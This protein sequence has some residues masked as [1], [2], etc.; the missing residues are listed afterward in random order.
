[1]NAYPQASASTT[2]PILY[3]NPHPQI[4]G[5]GEIGTVSS[6]LYGGV[7][8]TQN[9]ALLSRNIKTA[10]VVTNI[11]IWPNYNP[12]TYINTVGLYYSFDNN[13]TIGYSIDYFHVGEVWFASKYDTTTSIRG[14]P[15]QYYH[16]LRYAHTFFE[17]LSAGIGIKIIHSDLAP[18]IKSSFYTF[19][20][21]LGIDYRKKFQMT[22]KSDFRLD[23]GLSAQDIGPKIIYSKNQKQME[24][25]IPID[26]AAGTM[27]T[28]NYLINEKLFSF[29]MAYQVET[30]VVP[31][32]NIY[33][34]SSQGWL[35][36]IEK[37]NSSLL[38]PVYGYFGSF[39]STNDNNVMKP[40]SFIN[41]FGTEFRL[42][43]KENFIF[44]LRGGHIQEFE[45]KGGDNYY[46]LGAGIG[47]YGFR[48][49]YSRLFIKSRSMSA[50]G[51]NY[52]INLTNKK[53]IFIGN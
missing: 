23:I 28:Y 13:N 43:I 36:E 47:F 24:D 40:F 8:L 19:S 32:P 7:G 31:T 11:S 5:F 6:L 3:I 48:F 37:S 51:F 12:G 34:T 9:P 53:A 39:A 17:E 46:T 21:D 1:M 41:K 38:V 42:N 18:K 52:E 2:L 30:I 22:E 26:V 20:V 35:D 27:I 14:N 29:D 49:D 15:Y 25:Y 4:G 45:S 16:S 10:G 33:G 44:A 50:F